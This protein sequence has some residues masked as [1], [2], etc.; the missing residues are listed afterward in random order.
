VLEGAVNVAAS[1]A[2]VNTEG[3]ASSPKGS[4]DKGDSYVKDSGASITSDDLVAEVSAGAEA[5]VGCERAKAGGSVKLWGSTSGFASCCGICSIAWTA[6]G[7]AEAAL[8]CCFDDVRS[9]IGGDTFLVLAV[10]LHPNWATGEAATGAALAFA[11][12]DGLQCV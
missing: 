7:D 2:I 3:C 1:N 6:I 9:G 4:D 12:L 8:L 10:E 5:A 11:V